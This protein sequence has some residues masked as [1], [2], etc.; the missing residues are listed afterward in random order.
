[1]K[2]SSVVVKSAVKKPATRLYP[3]QKREAFARSRGKI[4]VDMPLCN[5]CTLCMLKCPTGAITVDKANKTWQIERL[6][7]VLCGACVGACMRK[8]VVMKGTHA[9]AVVDKRAEI[10]KALEDMTVYAW[11][12]PEKDDGAQAKGGELPATKDEGGGTPAGPPKT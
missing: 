2:M 1:M 8:A 5:Q 12:S 10:F 3:F 4:S 9:G 11:R 6:R 7:C